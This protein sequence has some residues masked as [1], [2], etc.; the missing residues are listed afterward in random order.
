MGLR[1]PDSQKSLHRQTQHRSRQDVSEGS[2][3]A[4]RESTSSAPLDVGFLTSRNWNGNARCFKT[5]FE[6]CF[7]TIHMSF[8]CGSCF[9][10]PCPAPC[11][12]RHLLPKAPL[13]PTSPRSSPHVLPNALG[14]FSENPLS[15][16]GKF[17]RT[18]ALVSSVIFK[19]C[20]SS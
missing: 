7:F 17:V 18:R 4:F 8:S 15:S 9:Q 3:K 2:Y 13:L 12:C 5:N 14:G 16:R 20:K 6:D 10:D 11:Q 1:Q 19:A